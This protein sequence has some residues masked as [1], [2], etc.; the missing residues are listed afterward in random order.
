[1]RTR[2]RTLQATGTHRLRPFGSAAALLAMIL[3][4][5]A[6]GGEP[7]PGASSGGHGGGGES[8]PP[9]GAAQSEA[10]AAAPSGYVIEPVT[11]GGRISG[12]VLLAGTPPPRE[13]V[14][15]TKDK[16]V[17]D[18]AK[19]LSEALV[20]DPEGGVR[21][22]VVAIE[23]IAAGKPFPSG[24][25]PI[26]D[27]HGC[28]FVPHVQLLPAGAEIDILN[29]DGILH[30]LHTFSEANPAINVAQPKF[31]KRIT[32][33]FDSP[34]RVRVICDVH[35]WMN[36]WIVVIGHPYHALTSADGSYDLEQVPPGR[37]TLTVW[38]ETLGKQEREVMVEPGGTVEASFTFGE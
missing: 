20:V 12:R 18:V 23:T 6:C 5:V 22:A 26:L 4:F 25:R 27:Q 9:A 31:K 34:E 11:G 14:T 8:A 13:P 2:S 7:P 19:H 1:M 3:S 35:S 33:S 28:W 16:G 21:D 30:N 10:P 29:S 24:D 38:H 37:Y 17:C 32:Q 15:I 36:A